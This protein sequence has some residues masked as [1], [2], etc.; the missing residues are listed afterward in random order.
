MSRKPPLLC[1]WAR[2]EAL[3]AP[4]L[5]DKL[6]EKFNVKIST[7]VAP[8]EEVANPTLVLGRKDGQVIA[9]DAWIKAA[10]AWGH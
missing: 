2:Q 4:Q 6:R 5:Q 10:A 3:S 8:G 9:P 1:D 7:W